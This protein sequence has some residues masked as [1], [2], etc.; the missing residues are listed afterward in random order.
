MNLFNT[1]DFIDFRRTYDGA[2]FSNNGRNNL[3]KPNSIWKFP[4]Y[5][6]AST[7]ETTQTIAMK[8][9]KGATALPNPSEIDTAMHRKNIAIEYIPDVNNIIC[10]LSRRKSI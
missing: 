1:N 6:N 7:D 4:D 9:N 5:V 8:I 10:S 3:S 2:K